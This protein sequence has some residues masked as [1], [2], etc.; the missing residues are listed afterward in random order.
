VKKYAD[1][2]GVL[3]GAVE[4]FAEEFRTG[5]YPGPEHSYS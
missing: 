4:D 1:L 3:R 5:A 2:R